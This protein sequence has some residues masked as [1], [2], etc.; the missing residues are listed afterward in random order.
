MR[1]SSYTS[2]ALRIFH[3]QM[4]ET[5]VRSPVSLKKFSDDL[6]SKAGHDHS[7]KAERGS[8][9]TIRDS[10]RQF[11]QSRIPGAEASSTRLEWD[12]GNG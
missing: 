3:T 12:E 8:R 2:L 11:A 5:E 1:S 4:P 9:A 6:C 7:I 10:I